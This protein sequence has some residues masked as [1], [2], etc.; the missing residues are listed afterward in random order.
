MHAFVNRVVTDNWLDAICNEDTITDPTF[1][2]TLNA[3]DA[4][5]AETKTLLSLCAK[6][7]GYLTV[8][9]GNG[10]YIVYVSTSDEQFWNL[11]SSKIDD[12][13]RLINAGGQI[14]DFP[15]RQVV[16]HDQVVQ[17]ARAYFDDGSLSPMLNWEKQA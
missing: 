12:D 7:D 10:N 2:V 14:G 15:A 1:D 16:D 11:L 3:I 17:A 8:G 13:V 5:N 9:G 6:D 4:L